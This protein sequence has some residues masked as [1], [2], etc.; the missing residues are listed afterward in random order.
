MVETNCIQTVG[1]QVCM[2]TSTAWHLR[3]VTMQIDAH[4][5]TIVIARRLQI[6]RVAL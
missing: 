4:A 1:R 5:F 6:T 2:A 3:P